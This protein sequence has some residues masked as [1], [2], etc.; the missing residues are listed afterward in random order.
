MMSGIDT[1]QREGGN[2]TSF[3]EASE[4]RSEVRER[5]KGGRGWRKRE[6]LRIGDGG[7]KME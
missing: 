2:I 6:G 3:P 1:K 5:I 7:E 4:G